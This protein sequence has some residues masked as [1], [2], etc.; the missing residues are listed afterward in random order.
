MN[1][2]NPDTLGAFIAKW[3]ASGA[4][5]R[6][7]AQAFLLDLC[8]VLEVEPPLPK[9][10]EEAANAYVFEKTVPAIAGS[11]KNFIDCYKR[12]HFVLEAKQGADAASGS[13]PLSAAAEAQRA[14]RPSCSEH[15]TGACPVGDRSG[16]KHLNRLGPC[17][18]RGAGV[19]WECDRRI[20]RFGEAGIERAAAEDDRCELGSGQ[21][22][23]SDRC[24]HT[25][26]RK[27]RDGEQILD[28]VDRLR[29]TAA[30]RRSHA[31]R[32]HARTSSATPVIAASVSQNQRSFG[33]IL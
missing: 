7:N 4:A 11:S 8:Q 17:V 13:T 18:R 26:D 2:P 3:A 10:P 16:Q 27:Q 31:A 15:R 9:T 28:L 14:N 19:G 1:H 30:P 23:E 29:G 25:G 12:G 22:G 6:A 5:E 20:D 21:D 32:A 24:D 33:P